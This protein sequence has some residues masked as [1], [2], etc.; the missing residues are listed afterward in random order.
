[1]HYKT[2][3]F[4]AI[5]M[6]SLFCFANLASGQQQEE[7]QPNDSICFDIPDS[8]EVARCLQDRELLRQIIQ[9][10]DQT[11]ANRDEKIRLLQEEIKLKDRIHEI[12]QREIESKDRAITAMGEVADRAIKLAET[13]KSN[14]IETYGPLG[15]IAIILVTIASV[16]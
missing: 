15:L 3:P 13:K 14:P 8:Q 4:L 11:I 1:M 10:K 5:L 16:L 2:L 12:D 9:V 6:I 7:V